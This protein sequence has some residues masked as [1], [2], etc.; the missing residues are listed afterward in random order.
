MTNWDV[1][2]LCTEFA[3][4]S[5]TD[6]TAGVS[7]VE[8]AHG[9]APYKPL[10]IVPLDPNV[11]VFEDRVAFAQHVSQLHQDIHDRVLS[12]YASY[13]QAGDLLLALL[14]APTRLESFLG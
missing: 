6:H 9:L 5:S 3:Y 4:H 11:R 8:T 13:K 12:Q 1:T 7:H 14:V 2:L 10:D